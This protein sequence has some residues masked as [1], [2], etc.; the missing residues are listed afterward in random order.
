MI[1]DHRQVVVYLGTRPVMLN[2][3]ISVLIIKDKK[4]KDQARETR[5]VYYKLAA[6][7]NLAC[8]LNSFTSSGSCLSLIHI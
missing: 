3:F 5:L 7:S 6:L 4:Y 8:Y 2:S 1:F